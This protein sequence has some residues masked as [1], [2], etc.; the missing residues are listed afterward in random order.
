MLLISF[1]LII[2]FLEDGVLFR[3]PLGDYGVGV[4]KELGLLNLFAARLNLLDHGLDGLHLLVLLGF[5]SLLF[6]LFLLDLLN[7]SLGFLLGFL[8]FLLGLLLSI[9]SSSKVSFLLL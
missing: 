4:L 6:L 1:F 2:N 8:C 9:L 5:T 3:L 7:V